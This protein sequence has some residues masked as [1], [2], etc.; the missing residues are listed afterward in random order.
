LDYL[1]ILTGCS[2][3]LFLQQISR[4]DVAPRADAPS[5]AARH[6]IPLLPTFLILPQGVLLLWP[7]FYATQRLLGR[8]QALTAGEWLW[9]F[10]W[11]GTVLLVA[12]E[13]WARWG[14]LP[15]FIKELDFSPPLVWN[16]IVLPSMAL[17]AVMIGLIGL[18]ARWEKTWTHTFGLL[19]LVWPVLPLAGLLVWTRD[20]NWV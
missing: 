12:Y 18:V 13:G 16:V 7:I 4:L 11:L 10:A 1:L 20:W 6:L 8:P 19:L 9:G 5:W 2:L 15:Q 3:S 14:T 17:V